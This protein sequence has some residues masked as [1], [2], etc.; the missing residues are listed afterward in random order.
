M[1]VRFDDN[2]KFC[3]MGNLLPIGS[4]AFA[5]Q[6]MGRQAAHPTDYVFQGTTN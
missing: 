5:F 4:F 1:N 6:S 2:L 3:R